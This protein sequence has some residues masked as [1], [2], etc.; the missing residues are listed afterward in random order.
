M[1]T[2]GAIAAWTA[3]LAA[4]MADDGTLGRP[5]AAGGFG[6][7]LDQFR[8]SG[9]LTDGGGLQPTEYQAH[10]V[11]EDAAEAAE[12]AATLAECYASVASLEEQIE[13]LKL[14]PRRRGGGSRGKGSLA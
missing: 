13:S 6:V 11:A 14:T 7:Q 10:A 1:G 4:R 2:D 5:V 9:C 12:G 8:A 3:M